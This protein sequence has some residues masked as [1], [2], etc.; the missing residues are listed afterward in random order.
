MTTSI[1]IHKKSLDPQLFIFL[2]ATDK[3]FRYKYFFNPAALADDFDISEQS[4]A[5]IRK[6]DFVALSKDLN[7]L[8]AGILRQP[9]ISA[10]DTCHDNKHSSSLGSGHSNAVHS[11]TCPKEQV[12]MLTEAVERFSKHKR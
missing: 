2:A 7:D 11:N 1:L 3:E 10:A 12:L 9:I 6:I 4:L 8:E 5:I